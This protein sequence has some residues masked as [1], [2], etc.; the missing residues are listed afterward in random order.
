MIRIEPPIELRPVLI[1]PRL[2]EQLKSTAI[3]RFFI[4]D[5]AWNCQP[6]FCAGARFAP[7]I[8]SGSN[9]LRPLIHSGEAPMAGAT[10]FFQYLWIDSFSVISY[11]QQKSIVIIAQL[12][13][14]VPGLCVPV[15][16]AQQL[17]CNSIDL[18]LDHRPF[19][20][21]VALYNHPQRRSTVTI[22]V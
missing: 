18:F 21:S 7:D 17:S 10:M 3:A 5:S 13:F 1:N 22:L 14:N 11:D 12:G 20:S 9:S 16:I 4:G 8:Q 2:P 19:R 6:N 15:S